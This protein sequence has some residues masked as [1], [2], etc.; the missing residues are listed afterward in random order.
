M[1]FTVNCD[2]EVR[3]TLC[4][5]STRTYYKLRRNLMTEILVL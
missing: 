3:R 2:R 5:L 4:L 1:V